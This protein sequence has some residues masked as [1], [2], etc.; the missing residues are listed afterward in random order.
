MADTA[1]AAALVVLVSLSTLVPTSSATAATPSIVIR[2]YNT[3]HVAH[4]QLRAM[5]QLVQ[6]L[7]RQAGI[8]ARW[9]ECRTARARTLDPCDDVIGIDEVVVR[10]VAMP[11]RPQGPLGDAFVDT[12]SHGGV[13]ATVFADRVRALALR[14]RRDVAVVLGRAVAHEVAHVLLG[15]AQHSTRGLMRA[16]WSDK[17]LLRDV[18]GEWG[19][20]AQEALWMRDRIVARRR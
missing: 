11:A 18:E 15:S 7:F 2:S 8:D 19:F 14:T 16:R 3:S 12:Q 10:I 9:R 20:S 4:H 17:E 13:L 1:R 6:A 5:P